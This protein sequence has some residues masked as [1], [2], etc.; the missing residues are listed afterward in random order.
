MTAAAQRVPR[1][2]AL[3]VRASTLPVWV[4]FAAV[5][6]SLIIAVIVVVLLSTPVRVLFG[7]PLP[8]VVTDAWGLSLLGYLLTP[9]VT[10]ACY[11]WD[12]IA[13]RSGVRADADFVRRPGLSSALRWV[14]AASIVVG[15]WHTLNLSVPLTEAWGLS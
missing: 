11:G 9:V 7:V 8:L 12:G 13:Q 1:R 3:F 4:G 15:I 14:V 10:I 6:A 2:S 5:I